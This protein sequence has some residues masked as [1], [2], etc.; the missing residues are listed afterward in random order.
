MR[1]LV[2]TAHLPAYCLAV[3]VVVHQCIN[4]VLCRVGCSINAQCHAVGP[5][6]DSFFA[7]IAQDISLQ[8]GSSFG[9]VAR[10]C[11]RRKQ[12]ADISVAIKFGNATVT[13]SGTG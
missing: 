1:R 7:P 9:I 8:T 12:C 2:V 6:P 11:I 10:I 13:Y 4:P 5:P 3:M